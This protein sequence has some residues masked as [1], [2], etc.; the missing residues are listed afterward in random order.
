MSC[1]NDRE[2]IRGGVL[3][4][5]TISDSQIQSSTISDSILDGCTITNLKAIDSP[6]AK[7][8]ADAISQLPKEQLAPLAKALADA[9]S[10]L[11][12]EQLDA[13]AKA[14]AEALLSQAGRPPVYSVGNKEVPVTMAGDRNGLMGKPAKW[15]KMGNFVVPAYNE[16]S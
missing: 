6:S 15:L 10:S 12:K 8:I 7:K 4:E 3:V 11:S 9:L 16:G 14:L 1:C 13:L 5:N 2:F